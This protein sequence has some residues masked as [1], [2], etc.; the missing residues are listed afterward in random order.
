MSFFLFEA[1]LALQSSLFGQRG[2]ARARRASISNQNLIFSSAWP[3]KE[4]YKRRAGLIG[5]EVA[6]YGGCFLKGK[7]GAVYDAL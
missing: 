7:A 2:G 3:C 5:H 6:E 4:R 1:S